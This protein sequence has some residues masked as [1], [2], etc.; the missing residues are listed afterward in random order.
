MCPARLHDLR[1]RLKLRV[2]LVL[3]LFALCLWLMI[4]RCQLLTWHRQRLTLPAVRQRLR[5]YFLGSVSVTTMAHCAPI[6]LSNYLH[7][8]FS[9]LSCPSFSARPLLLQSL[10]QCPTHRQA[11]GKPLA[12]TLHTSTCL[13]SL[14]LSEWHRLAHWHRLSLCRQWLAHKHKL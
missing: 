12:K 4:R 1:Q 6:L 10:H 14:P 11:A 5:R 13:C 7:N 3:P 9:L 8:T 2:P